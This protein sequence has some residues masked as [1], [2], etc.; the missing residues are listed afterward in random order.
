MPRRAVS[1]IFIMMVAAVC[2]GGG[3]AQP[4]RT[5]PKYTGPTLPLVEV[6]NR[7]NENNRRIPTLFARHEIEADIVEE[8]KSR[9]I[10]ADGTLFV[11]KPREL[12]LR[13]RKVID[14]IF[15]MGSTGEVYWF[16]VYGNENT[17]WWGHYRNVGKPCSKDIPIRPDLIGEVLSITDVNTNL[18][19]WPAPTIRYNNDLDVYMV[20]WHSPL[21]DRLVTEREVYYDRATLLPLKV[22]LFDPHGRPAL[23]A[24]LSGHEPVEIEGVPREQWPRIATYYDL[25]FPETGSK[26]RM[27]L[28]SVELRSST[29]HPRE[30]TIRFRDDPEVAKVIQLDE[31]CE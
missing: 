11:R 25:L 6:I 19:E 13:G 3:C 1:S 26:M 9:F 5:R 14:D 28:T 22:I 7:I 12:W 21:P 4:P 2:V 8:G 29:G 15:E 24:N 10:N 23:R 27:R 18:T 30:G 16:T 31:A 20:Q 17:R